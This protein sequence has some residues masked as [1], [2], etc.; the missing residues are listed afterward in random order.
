MI[1][2]KYFDYYPCSIYIYIYIYIKRVAEYSFLCGKGNKNHEL[3]T[4]FFFCA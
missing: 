1:E 4:G 2:I 3:E